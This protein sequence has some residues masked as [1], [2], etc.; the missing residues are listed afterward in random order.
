MRSKVVLPEPDG[1]NSATKAPCGA[2][3]LAPFSAGKRANFLTTESI[4]RDM[5]F[6]S[7]PVHG[8]QL[9]GIAPF[10]QRFEGQ[11]HQG[12]EPQQGGDGK[13]ADIIVIVVKQLDMQR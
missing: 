12:Q 9:I 11:G 1:P 3:R 10:Q 5:K 2:V 7:M 6:L 4:T 8:G 13:G